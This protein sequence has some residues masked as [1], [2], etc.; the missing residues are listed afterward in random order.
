[1]F[2]V[3][4]SI[5]CRLLFDVVGT[6][7]MPVSHGRITPL[8]IMQSTFFI[9]FGGGIPSLFIPGKICMICRSCVTG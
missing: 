9:F 3:I 6:G 4:I 1:M 8:Y 5:N 7:S 2:L